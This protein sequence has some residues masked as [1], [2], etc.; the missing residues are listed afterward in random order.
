M[1]EWP[2][3]QLGAREKPDFLSPVESNWPLNLRSPAPAGAK[4]RSDGWKS[5]GD[6]VPGKVTCL[7]DLPRQPVA[8]KQ[9]ENGSM[10]P[11]EVCEGGL[12]RI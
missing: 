3:A 5:A 7:A 8:L 10:A 12:T 11:A 9:C 1:S 6:N 2:R 4:S